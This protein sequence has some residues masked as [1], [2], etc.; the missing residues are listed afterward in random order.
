MKSRRRFWLLLLCSSA[1]AGWS[2]GTE[3]AGRTGVTSAR[4]TTDAPRYLLRNVVSRRCLAVRADVPTVSACRDGPAQEWET[5]YGRGFTGGSGP[6]D[7]R[8]L[9]HTESRSCLTREA[10]G[11]LRVAPCTA[12]ALESQAFRYDAD[13]SRRI[14]HLGGGSGC[15][16]DLEGALRLVACDGSPN[17]RWRLVLR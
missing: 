8:T 3:V 6:F 10:R 5:G 9:R 17:Q 4:I 12:G 13:L 15:L 2:D 7:Y 11:W 1:A 16:A 14:V